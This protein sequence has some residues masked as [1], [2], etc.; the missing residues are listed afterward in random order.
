MSINAIRARLV[1]DLGAITGITKVYHDIPNVAPAPPDLPCFV[2]DMRDPM[3]TTRSM[4]NST[5]DYTWHFDL[6]LLFK[7]EGLGNPDENF[8]SLE[9]F[10]KLTIDKL[11]ANFTG[12][13]TWTLINK[14][15]NTLEFT[16][17]LMS[18]T[19]AP[20][21]ANRFWGFV[22][23]LDITEE[24]TTTMSTGS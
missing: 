20:D 1:T 17:G 21:G 22:G 13:G 12:A 8:S 7:P 5:V 19:N 24:V 3:V 18:I 14:D 15:T 23:T 10:I 6:T 9:D 16:G 4:T 11:Y 2:L